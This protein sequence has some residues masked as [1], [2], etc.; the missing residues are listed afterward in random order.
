VLPGWQLRAQ[1]F[2]EA[3][4]NAITLLEGDDETIAEATGYQPRSIAKW[5]R[6]L[7]DFMMLGKKKVTVTEGCQNC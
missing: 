1:R 5:K 6:E 2:D 7:K 3:G 4:Y